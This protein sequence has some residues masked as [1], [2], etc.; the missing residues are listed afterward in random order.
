MKLIKRTLIIALAIM[1]CAFCFTGCFGA[2]G[3]VA[4]TYKFESMTYAGITIEAGDNYLGTTFGED[5]MVLTLNEDNTAS[6]TQTMTGLNNTMT[7]TW[8]EGS[9][10]SEIVITLDGTS[11]T[12]TVSG[13][14]ITMTNTSMGAEVVLAK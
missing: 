10:S 5:Y 4:G 1:A 2:K 7:G 14:K 9:S 13:G 8:A 3:G 11:Q 6:M 12:A